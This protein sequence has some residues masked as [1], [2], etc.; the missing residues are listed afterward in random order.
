MPTK[1]GSFVVRYKLISGDTALVE[2]WGP[3]TPHE[4]E[5]VFYP[6]HAD[7]L[8]THYCA[9]GNQ[10]RLRVATASSDAVVFR[11]VDVTN[12]AADQSMLVERTLRFAGDT[13]D[14]T[15]IYRGPDGKDETTTYH[16]TRTAVA[17]P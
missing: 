1:S 12:K 7:L 3:G 14:D 13:F 15:E 2:E 5:T 8:L 9:Q 11:F 4:T 6:D 16:F 10:P 17:P